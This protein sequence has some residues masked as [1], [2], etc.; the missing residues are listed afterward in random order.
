MDK[1][2]AAEVARLQNKLDAVR[3]ILKDIRAEQH[4]RG[5]VGVVTLTVPA[6]WLTDLATLALRDIERY[7]SEIDKL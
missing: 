7:E 6:S 5:S 4:E 3:G 1:E 2:K